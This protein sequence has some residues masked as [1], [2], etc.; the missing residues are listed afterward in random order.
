MDYIA[1]L[2]RAVR[3]RSEQQDYRDRGES[4]PVDLIR[5][6]ECILV[7]AKLHDLLSPLSSPPVETFWEMI[8][9]ELRTAFHR[10]DL[11]LTRMLKE[12]G[13][14]IVREACMFL[15]GVI[16]RKSFPSVPR[17]PVY[18]LKVHQTSMGHGLS[19]I[20]AAHLP[21]VAS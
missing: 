14:V 11:W 13:P 9:R 1:A 3:Y 5:E 10:F 6:F 16:L 2:H 19:R 21:V 4:P 20:P 12:Y 18:T 15:I 8:W 17:Q 7:R